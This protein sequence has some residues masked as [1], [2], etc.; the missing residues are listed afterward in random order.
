MTKGYNNSNKTAPQWTPHL[1][2]TVG[3]RERKN[4]LPKEWLVKVIQGFLR[5]ASF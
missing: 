5:I 4:L 3:V 2:S 1:W